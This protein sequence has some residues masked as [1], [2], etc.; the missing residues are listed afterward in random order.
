MSLT[1][2]AKMRIGLSQASTYWDMLMK[3]AYKKAEQRV[4][5]SR[6]EES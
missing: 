1:S 3:K 5:Q 6:G 4:K 2:S